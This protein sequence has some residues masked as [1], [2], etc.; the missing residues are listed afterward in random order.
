LAPGQP[1]PF[2]GVTRLS[3]QVRQAGPV[4]LDVFDVAGRLVVSLVDRV[5][6]AGPHEVVWDG[7]DAWGHSVGSGVYFARM[8]AAGAI[9]RQSLIMTR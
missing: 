6:N 2:H 5:E 1:N 9:R 3:Y 7:R 8:A 4:R